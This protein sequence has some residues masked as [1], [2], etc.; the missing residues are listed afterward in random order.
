[1]KIIKFIKREAINWLL[2]SLPF[3]YILMVYDRL[4][5]FAP[6]QIDSEQIIYYNLLFIM[7]LAIIMYIVLLVK[8]SIVPKTA[9]HDNLKS[10][11]RIRTLM[12]VFFSFTSLIFITK[13]IGIPF[14]WSK[15]GFILA[16]G[17]MAVFGNLYPTIGYNYII[18]I[19]NPWTQSNEHI[20]KK[21]HRFAGKIFFFGGLIGALYGILFNVNSVPYMPIIYVGYTFTLLF[22]SHLYSYLLY[23]QFQS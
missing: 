21:T 16:M 5:G 18:G 2:I 12:L 3:I 20:W 9:F 23:R 4:P 15:T 1:M 14:N 17:F 7:G 19:K 13:E 11:H 6:F 10:F 8:P 22:I